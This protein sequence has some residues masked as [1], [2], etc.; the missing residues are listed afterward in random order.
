MAQCVCLSDGRVTMRMLVMLLLTPYL[1][2]RHKPLQAP[3][4]S[5]FAHLTSK[6]SFMN[7][8]DSDTEGVKSFM[9]DFVPL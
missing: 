4:C 7:D 8:G 5:L 3:M 2:H 9:S 1:F 6:F